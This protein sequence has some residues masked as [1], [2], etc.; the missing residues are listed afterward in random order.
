MDEEVDV[1]LG[2]HRLLRREPLGKLRHPR[3]DD[4]RVLAAAS[5]VR[6]H[7]DSLAGLDVVLAELHTNP[8]VGTQR[9][10]I[11]ALI[12]RRGR[13][14]VLFSK[15]RTVRDRDHAGMCPEVFLR[16]PLAE[17]DKV[18]PS[19]PGG[20]SSTL[21]TGSVIHVEPVHIHANT[22]GDGRMVHA[23]IVAESGRTE[24][25]PPS[26]AQASTRF[27]SAASPLRSTTEG[28]PTASAAR[29]TPPSGPRPCAAPATRGAAWAA[30]SRAGSAG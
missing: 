30:R 5:A 29:R 22:D 8:R 26:L 12:A 28:W 19:P 23:L 14:A 4:A 17:P 1:P 16:Q 2:P 27:D 18:E 6:A 15:R 3:R 21:R 25:K 20:A 11:G 9:P 7:Q 24:S 13:V 10:E